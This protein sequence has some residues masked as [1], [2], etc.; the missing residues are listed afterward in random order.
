LKLLLVYSVLN[1]LQ[2]KR[3]NASATLSLPLHLASKCQLS[4]FI[5]SN[6]Y[7]FFTKIFISKVK[8]TIK[9]KNQIIKKLISSLF[10]LLGNQTRSEG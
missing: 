7:F 4:H 9:L 8:E 5:S 2:V 10:P 3:T 1:C 6:F